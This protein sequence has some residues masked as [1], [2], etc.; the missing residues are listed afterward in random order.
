MVRL[1]RRLVPLVALLVLVPLSGAHASPDAPAKVR[2]NRGSAFLRQDGRVGITIR[3]TC[4]PG[5]QAFELDVDVFQ[6]PVLGQVSIVQ[7]GVV[8]CDDRWHAV[9][10]RVTPFGGTFTHGPATVSVFL[11]VFDPDEGDLDATTS[12]R[13]RI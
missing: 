13:V 10:V 1:V 12:A 4:Q 7:A 2:V 11:G 8:T 5:L 3:A 6:D 9:R